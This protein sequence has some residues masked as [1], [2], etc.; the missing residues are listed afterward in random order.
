[1]SVALRQHN[2]Y[3]RRRA[4][5]R[6][7]FWSRDEFWAKHAVHRAAIHARSAVVNGSG[8]LYFWNGVCRLAARHCEKRFGPVPELLLRRPIGHHPFSLSSPEVNAWLRVEPP[9]RRRARIFK[10]SQV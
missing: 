8:R 6:R 1:M 10:T 9:F 7:Y 5:W 2:A 3:A 4:W